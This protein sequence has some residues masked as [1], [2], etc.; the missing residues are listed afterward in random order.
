MHAES[1]DVFERCHYRDGNSMFSPPLLDGTVQLLQ[2]QICKRYLTTAC[3]KQPACL[4]RQQG[5]R[6]LL[7]HAG[8]DYSFHLLRVH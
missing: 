2:E 7:V 8:V 4:S 6:W 1:P 5:A 3:T